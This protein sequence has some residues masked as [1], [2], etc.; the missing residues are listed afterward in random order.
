[1]SVFHG[2]HLLLSVAK[3]VAEDSPPSRPEQI[4]A[5]GLAAGPCPACENSFGGHQYVPLASTWADDGLEQDVLL[6]KLLDEQ[7]W[8]EVRKIVPG[9]KGGGL[10]AAYAFRCVAKRRA[11]WFTMF[12]PVDGAELPSRTG[13]N[14]LDEVDSWRLAAA[15]GDAEWRSFGEIDFPAKDPISVSSFLRQ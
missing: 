10:M 6:W 7:R 1:M 13:G 9:P 2:L 5:F 15:V 14:A 11:G 4:Q 8:D 12:H 3:F